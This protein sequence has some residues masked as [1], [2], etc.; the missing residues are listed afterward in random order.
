MAAKPCGPV[1]GRILVAAGAYFGIVF[2]IGFVFGLVRVA[3]VAPIIGERYAELAEMPFMFVALTLAARFVV[4]RFAGLRTRWQWVA[5]GVAALALL[6]AAELLLTVMLAGRSVESY[7]AAR[8]PVSGLVYLAMLVVFAAMPCLLWRAG[9][10]SG[11]R[12]I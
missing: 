2:G 1:P 12:R 11:S 9:A 8:D 10:R 3:L 4:R 7:L 6:V 5:V